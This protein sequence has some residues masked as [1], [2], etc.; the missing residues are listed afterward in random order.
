MTLTKLAQHQP[1]V[2]DNKRYKFY[3]TKWVP[4]R[5]HPLYDAGLLPGLGSIG[6]A[7]DFMV[8]V[9]ADCGLTRLYAHAEAR[10]N[11]ERSERWKRLG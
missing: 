8:R 1:N 3:E 11:L 7:A 4:A 5:G 9:C 2:L 10:G 6:S